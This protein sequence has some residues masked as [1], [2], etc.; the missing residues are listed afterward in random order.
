M[1]VNRYINKYGLINAH[2]NERVAENCPLWSLQ[3]LLLEYDQKLDHDMY[4]FIGLCKIKTGLYNQRPENTGS[5]E[6]KMSPDQLIAFVGYLYKFKKDLGIHKEIWYYLY[7]HLFTYDNIS[8]EINFNR[9]QQPQ[10][11]LFL[12]ICA[13][14]VYLYPLLFISI[15]HSC[16]FKRSET[17]GRLKSWTIM[18]VLDMKLTY[19]ICTLINPNSWVKIFQIY[20]KN[21]DHP[22][23]AMAE[24]RLK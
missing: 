17:S 12:A 14:H 15:I 20:F 22:V 11:V 21:L 10:A 16:L 1:L 9:L 19:S 7:K 2:K 4:N 18:K 13:G 24:W 5:K 8:D 3:Y 6:D 23:R